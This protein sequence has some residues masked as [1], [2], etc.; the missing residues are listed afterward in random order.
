MALVLRSE[1][2]SALTSNE[3]DGN[4][5]YLLGII[6]ALESGI[7]AESIQSISYDDGQITIIGSEGTVWG[8][9]DLVVPIAALG[10]WEPSMAL[11]VGGFLTHEGAL[12]LALVNGLT[13]SDF[14]TDVTL[15]KI[16]V[17]AEAPVASVVGYD[18]TASG[19]TATDMQAALDEIVTRLVALETP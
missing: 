18:N 8:P 9:F 10:E 19:L 3:I 5:S 15:G 12:C 4:F 16:A 6:T 13:G 17:M 11:T 14:D 7:T 1:K 2:G